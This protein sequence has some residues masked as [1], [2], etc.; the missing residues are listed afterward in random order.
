MAKIDEEQYWRLE[1][2]KARVMA[3]NARGIHALAPWY[4]FYS[5]LARDFERE[6]DN[7]RARRKQETSRGS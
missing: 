2:Q 4:H 1:A 7:L 5:Y 6:L 3:R